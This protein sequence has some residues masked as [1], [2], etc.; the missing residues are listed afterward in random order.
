MTSSS[1][2]IDADQNGD[3]L[4]QNLVESEVRIDIEPEIETI[5]NGNARKSEP[6]EIP[7]FASKKVNVWIQEQH[8]NF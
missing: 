5:F 7:S 2:S 6:I 3:R 4:R 8:C 1:G